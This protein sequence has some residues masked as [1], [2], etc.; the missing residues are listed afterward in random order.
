[1]KRLSWSTEEK[2]I[3][4]VINGPRYVA[5]CKQLDKTKVKPGTRLASDMITLS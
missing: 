2:V 1:M 3:V 5:S 4:K